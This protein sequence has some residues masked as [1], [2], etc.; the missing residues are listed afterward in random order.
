MNPA[1]G[2][3]RL[4]GDGVPAANGVRRQVRMVHLKG[5]INNGDANETL[6]QAL[7]PGGITADLLVV[8]LVPNQRIVRVKGLVLQNVQFR[9]FHI[10][11]VGDCA[12]R[13]Q[14]SSGLHRNNRHARFG[15]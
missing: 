9:E 11:P 6:A 15:D 13:L 10:R 4:V 2:G 3:D 7:V 12:R 5:W 8:P 14:L 1:A